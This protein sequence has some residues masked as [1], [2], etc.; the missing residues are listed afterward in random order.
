MKV[1]CNRCGAEIL[2]R[3]ADRHGG[4]CV[5]C[6]RGQTTTCRIC[7]G[8]A[9]RTMRGVELG[10]I[11][12]KCSGEQ[13]KQRPTAIRAFVERAGE[14]D[15]SLLV[16][17]YEID[18]RLRRASLGG[19]AGLGLIDPPEPYDSEV[20][21]LNAFAFAGTGG[22]NVHFSLIS[23]KGRVSDASPVVITVPSA[24]ETEWDANFIVGG[25]LR[26]FLS[27]GCQCGYDTLEDLAYDWDAT[28]DELQNGLPSEEVFEDDQERLQIFRAELG[29]QPWPNVR[30]RLEAL[31]QQK[32]FILRFPKPWFRWFR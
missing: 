18:E 20:T 8:R 22:E 11:C 2:A 4:L 24:G 16:R 28:I 25:S 31:Q 30:E 26:E 3:T 1:S 23:V 10:D 5:P 32:R 14:G 17:L 6:S 21:P 12:T 27:L 9:F 15:C 29:L 19:D 13:E 7:G